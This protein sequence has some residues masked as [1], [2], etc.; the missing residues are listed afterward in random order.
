METGGVVRGFVRGPAVPIG[1]QKQMP[2]EE[3]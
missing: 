1:L 2:I 3:R